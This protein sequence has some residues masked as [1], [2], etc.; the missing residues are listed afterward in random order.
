MKAPLLEYQVRWDMIK[1]GYN[2]LDK[3]DIKKYWM[4]RLS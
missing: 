2:P 4:E 1:N 3:E